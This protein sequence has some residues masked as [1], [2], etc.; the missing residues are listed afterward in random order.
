MAAKHT[1]SFNISVCG[2]CIFL[3][4]N[5]WFAPMLL[6]HN[7]KSVVQRWRSFFLQLTDHIT[8]SCKFY[9]K[10]ICID[11]KLCRIGLCAIHVLHLD[12]QT[13]Y[14]KLRINKGE[15]FSAHDVKVFGEVKVQHRSFL[16]LVLDRREWSATSP[17]SFTPGKSPQHPLN[18]MLGRTH[19]PPWRFGQQITPSRLLEN[20][21]I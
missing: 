6:Y 4:T 3:P 20:W 13:V 15:I 8:S 18:G 16:T 2:G 5:N 17:G 10:R 1:H 14:R 19:N 7:F 11:V 12:L 9:G 21:G